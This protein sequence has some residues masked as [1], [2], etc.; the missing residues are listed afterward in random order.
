[1]LRKRSL[2]ENERVSIQGHVLLNEALMLEFDTYV[3]RMSPVMDYIISLN[4]EFGLYGEGG[5]KDRS[6]L[7][8]FKY[9]V[10]KSAVVN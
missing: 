6:T 9:D 5:L 4:D 7:M 10:R 8:T 1:M 3:A 2:I